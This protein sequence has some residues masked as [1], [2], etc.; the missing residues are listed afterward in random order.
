MADKVLEIIKGEE[1][2]L[3]VKDCIEET[4]IFYAQY[5]AAASMLENILSGKEETDDIERKKNIWSKTEYENNIIAFCGDRGEGKSS[6]MITFVKAVYNYKYDKEKSFLFDDYENI[7]NTYFEEPIIIDPSM[8]DGIHNVLDIVLAALYKKFKDLY[9]QNNQFFYM[10]K[11]EELLDQFQKVYKRISLIN[12]Q[13]KMLDDEYDY[14]GN[15][16]KLSKLGQ[17]IELKDE[18][19]LLIQMYLETMMK[20]K[21]VR[22]EKDGNIIIAIDDLDLCSSHAYKMAE[23]I[24]KYL[25]L[26]NVVIVMAVKVE[27]LEMC[28]KEKNLAD[29]KN[30]VTIT[31]QKDEMFEE[32]ENMSER[33]VAKLIPKA[34]RNYLPN[35]QLLNDVK[36]SYK[37]KRVQKDTDDKENIIL[38]RGDSV[39]NIIL[40]LIYDKTGMKFLEGKS[41]ANYF[42]PDNLRDAVNLIVLLVDM[43][44][45]KKRDIVYYNNI[46]KFISYFE[47]Q[48]LSAQFSLNVCKEVQKLINVQS[49]LHE[50][51]ENLLRTC[52]F[53]KYS[54]PSTVNYAPESKDSFSQVMSWLEIYW[55]N[56]FEEED[57]KYAYLFHIL[58][59]IRLNELLRQKKYDELTDF[60]GGYLWAWN[61]QNV[62]PAAQ[63]TNI[64][65]SRF[66]LST[67]RSFNNI[68]MQL[69]PKR[70]ILLP[71]D[72]T[73]QYYV[74][75]ISGED[76][77]KN[78]KI[79]IWLLLGMLS[80]TWLQDASQRTIMTYDTVSIISTNYSVLNYVHISL[81]N[82]ILSLCNLNCVYKKV[83]MECLGISE[84]EFQVIIK[85][86]EELNRETIEIFRKIVTN[87]DVAMEYKEYCQKRKEI[88]KSGEKSGEERTQEAVNIFFENTQKFVE[89]YFGIVVE[90]L[91]FLKLPYDDGEIEIDISRLYGS[92]VQ[93]AVEVENV[94]LTEEAKL[95]KEKER[96]VRE[97]AFKLRGN[98]AGRLSYAKV[99]RFLK[100]RTAENT[101]NNMDN[102]ASNIQSYRS[103]HDEKELGEDEILKLC[104]FYGKIVE[105]YLKDSKAVLPKELCDEYRKIVAGYEDVCRQG[106]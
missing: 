10:D 102:L 76:K 1:F 12:N 31:Q 94:P 82:Y 39:N 54:W 35:V 86:I 75:A 23:Q 95:E 6:A 8:L 44:E 25:I 56:A 38:D 73:T 26:P 81:E 89:Q 98:Y 80:N 104:E 65:R 50:R 18:L 48:W 84:E 61:F 13:E 7:K 62:L 90:N 29:Y 46:E 101:K 79:I 49:K 24:R 87:I 28:V 58:Y 91:H 4:D 105:V 71:M 59:T 83:N 43:E 3:S 72:I 37:S 78:F 57:E 5:A 40:N 45:P 41:D 93:E 99:V 30:V 64:D 17:S 88:K 11:R 106:D 66:L 85:E 2:K 22:N 70:G 63:G 92:L 97:F 51:T 67:V 100:V 32:M 15:I 60:M 47:H 96:L 68:A 69:Y 27:Q 16:S 36:I 21:G 103:E 33:Y 9:N 53:Q 55:K 77:N 14:E 74:K 52:Y 34:R 42:L 19:K 20:A